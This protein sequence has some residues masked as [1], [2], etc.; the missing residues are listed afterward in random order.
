MLNPYDGKLNFCGLD[1]GFE[2]YPM[3]YLT[4]L[5]LENPDEIFKS[6]MCLKECPAKSDKKVTLETP[7]SE[8]NKIEVESTYESKIVL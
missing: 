2:E 1:E 3:L 5:G 8:N 6:G 7:S 4:N